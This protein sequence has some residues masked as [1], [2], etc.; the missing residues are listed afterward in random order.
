MLQMM[1]KKPS[2]PVSANKDV[3]HTLPTDK[4]LLAAIGTIALLH[5]HLDNALRMTIKDV[6]GLSKDETLDATARQGSRDLR[7]RVRRLA[8]QRF[9]ESTALVKLDT[10]LYRAGRATDTRNGIL[11][12]VWGTELDGDVMIRRED[13]SFEPGKSEEELKEFAEEL[14]SIIWEFIYARLDDDGFLSKALK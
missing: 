11:H 8:K 5:A 3:S 4:N 12:S 14:R 10:L 2:A 6:T 9:G 7:E 1:S 13:H